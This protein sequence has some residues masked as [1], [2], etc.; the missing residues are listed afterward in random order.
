MA[1]GFLLI[2][3]GIVASWVL[4][5]AGMG[6]AFTRRAR[7]KGAMI[8]ALI[9]MMLGGVCASVAC[10]DAPPHSDVPLVVAE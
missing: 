4:L 5:G 2:Y 1:E 3:L 10:F 9:G 8:G 6:C 7:S